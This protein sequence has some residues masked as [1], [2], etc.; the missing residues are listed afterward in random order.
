[1]EECHLLKGFSNSAWKGNV[2]KSHLLKTFSNSAWKGCV[3]EIPS[4]EGFF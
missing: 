4:V 3:E 2:E 1:M